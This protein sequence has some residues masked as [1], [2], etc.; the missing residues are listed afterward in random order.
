MRIWIAALSSL[1]LVNCSC[2]RDAP[3]QRAAV[4]QTPALTPTAD[5]PHSAESD[6]PDAAG[7]HARGQAMRGATAVVHEYIGV[8]LNDPEAA[9]QFWSGQQFPPRRDDAALQ[10]LAGVRNLRI[11]NDAGIA[12]DDAQPPQA[13]EIP[14]RIRVT[15]DEGL[16]QLRGWYRVRP[17]I[18][19]DSWEITSASLQPVLN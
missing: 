9:A 1:L 5:A 14:V 13:I 11:D 12:L 16:T 4:D 19:A 8:L 3:A 15:T 18:G 10:A 17:R 6:A 2:Q 7:A